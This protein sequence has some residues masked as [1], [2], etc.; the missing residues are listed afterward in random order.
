M[1]E[2]LKPFSRALAFLWVFLAYA[3]GLASFFI[4]ADIFFSKGYE[5]IWAILIADIV[6]TVVVFIFSYIFK[7]TSFYDPYWSLLPIFIALL[8]AFRGFTEGTYDGQ[9]NMIILVLI[10]FWGI[11]LTWNWARGWTGLHHIDWRYV[12]FEKKFPKLFWLLSFFGLQMMPTVLVFLGCLP[13]FGAM[14]DAQNDFNWLDILAATFTFTAILIELISDN[15]LRKFVKT[16][17]EGTTLTKGLWKYSRHPNYF[18]EVAFWW[19]IYLFA[20]AANPA[21]WWTIIGAISMT[22]LFHFISI[23]MIDKRHL[24]RRKDYEE[25]MKKV[26][27]WVPWFPKEK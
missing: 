24:E 8:L 23:P 7:N 13:L 6:C 22:I 3:I 18:G 4:T 26:P 1:S 17:E 2:Q 21:Y 27:R 10:A 15:Q 9:R 11:R 16:K 19:G 12:D 14:T 20:I 5:P 25:V